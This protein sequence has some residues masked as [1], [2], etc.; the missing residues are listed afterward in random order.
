MDKQDLQANSIVTIV[1]PRLP[2]ALWLVGKVTHILPSKD[3]RIRTAEVAVKD[4]SYIRPVA[5]LVP[6]PALPDG[7]P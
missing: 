3:G 5:H 4:K 1:D 6:L 2:R 7:P